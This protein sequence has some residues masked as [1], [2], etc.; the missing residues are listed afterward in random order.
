MEFGGGV[1]RRRDG[2][3]VRVVRRAM[4]FASENL[5][6]A[7]EV[8]RKRTDISLRRDGSRG[9]LPSS[10]MLRRREEEEKGIAAASY[11][12]VDVEDNDDD[13][14]AMHAM[15]SLA[16]LDAATTSV[17]VKDNGVDDDEEERRRKEELGR[18]TWTLLHTY[19]AALPEGPNAMSKQQRRDARALVTL[20][21]RVYP[22]EE[23]AS[24]WK[25]ILK[26]DP[27]NTDSAE[28]FQH[29]LC[30]A[31]NTVNRRYA[32]SSRP[33][34]SHPTHFFS[35]CVLLLD[36]VI[37]CDALR[38]ALNMA[39][40]D[41]RVLRLDVCSHSMHVVLCPLLLLHLFIPILLSLGKPSFNCSNVGA[42]WHALNCDSVC[43]LGGS[44]GKK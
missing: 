35:R 33:S 31:H 40:M 17:Q 15:R 3:G 12:T 18:A 36:N 21:T 10:S 41:A 25:D 43:V 30:G 34:L 29:W 24:H 32:T 27:P 20:L 19:A 7:V 37:M 39:R 8:V 9:A 28:A 13:A 4:E 11:M 16:S 1:H 23:C 5:K 22:C 26:A 2:G 6:K 42:R 44:S 38:L 14:R